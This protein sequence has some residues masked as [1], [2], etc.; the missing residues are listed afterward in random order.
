MSVRS[1]QLSRLILLICAAAAILISIGIS[2]SA[3]E[4]ESRWFAAAVALLLCLIGTA[5]L[6]RFPLFRDGTHTICAAVGLALCLCLRLSLFDHISPDYVS[7]LGPWTQTMRGMSVRQALTTP[8]GDYNMPYLYVLL[9]IS[10]MPYYDVY[11]IKLISVLTDVFLALAV[12]KLAALIA[13]REGLILGA[14]L[15]A[16]L[17]PTVWLNSAYWAQCDGVYAC[18]ALWGLYFGLKKRPVLSVVMLAFSFAFKLQAVFILP[19]LA[20]LLVKND[21][22]GKHLLLFP[23]TFL[24]VMLPAL[25]AGRGFSDTFGI[26]VS[27]TDAYPYLSLNAP[28]FWSL[29]PDSYFH[30]INPA[31]VLAAGIAVLLLLYGFL[32]QTGRL[33]AGDLIDLSLIFCLT[34]PWLLPRMHER[35]FYLAEVLSILYAVHHPRRIWVALIQLFGGFLIYCSYLFGGMLI[36]SNELVAAIFGLMLVYLILALYRQLDGRTSYHRPSKEETHHEKQTG[37]PLE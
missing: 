20:F 9:I 7:F 12:G 3:M 24:A 33:R 17:A 19:I 31:P 1:Q 36:L 4:D 37:I 21:L 34:I 27:Q 6:V 13:R 29:I 2:I 16:L 35:Y 32:R 11:C 25:L 22:E 30:E 10:R 18:F 8:I 14:F 26:Y 28:S 23:V 15:A 5:L